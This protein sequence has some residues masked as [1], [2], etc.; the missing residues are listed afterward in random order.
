MIKFIRRIFC[1]HQFVWNERRRR[2]VC[3]KC[4]KA[5]P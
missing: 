5:K 3:W 4:G 1:A 2:E